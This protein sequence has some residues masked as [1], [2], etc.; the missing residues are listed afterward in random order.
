MCSTHEAHQ[1]Y[2]SRCAV[3]V[4][5]TRSTYKGVQYQWREFYS[6][7]IYQKSLMGMAVVLHMRVC[8]ICE[9][10]PQYLE[11]TPKVSMRVWAV[12]LRH[13]QSTHEGNYIHLPFIKSHSWVLWVCLK[14]TAHAHMYFRCASWV[15]HTLMSTT[16]TLCKVTFDPLC[17]DKCYTIQHS[18]L[19][20]LSSQSSLIDHKTSHHAITSLQFN[21]V[22]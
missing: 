18:N 16:H 4:R 13:T 9:A 6:F 14:G 7:T 1:Q 5:H 15:L 20:K 17:T 8:S 11:G 2:S 19:S 3:P 21:V 10:H 22:F 12:S